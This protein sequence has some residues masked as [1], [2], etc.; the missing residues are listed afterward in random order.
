VRLKVEACGMQA[1]IDQPDDVDLEDEPVDSAAL[2]AENM[3]S[4][5]ALMTEVAEAVDQLDQRVD[6]LEA[7]FQSWR[8]G[9]GF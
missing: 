1:L 2:L 4:L 5:I 7:L 6:S 9:A 3:A 8:G